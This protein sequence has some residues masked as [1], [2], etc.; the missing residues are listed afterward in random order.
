MKVDKN[1]Y[2]SKLKAHWVCRGFQDKF[3]WD[4]QADSPTATR[5][6]FRLVAQC[7]ANHY[8]D[9]FQLDLKTACLRGEH[10]NLSSRSVVV[11]LPPDI[12]LPPWMVAS[13]PSSGLWTERCTKEMVGRLDKFLRSVGLE[14]TRADRCTY[15]AY[16]GIEGKKDKSYLSTG[17]FS[18]EKEPEPEPP[19]YLKE[20]APH[21]MSCY[22]CDE[23]SRIAS[24]RA[25]ALL[26]LEGTI[27][28]CQQPMPPEA[29]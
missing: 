15:G 14:P 22:A 29:V 10:Y 20:L 4:Q 11:Q 1:G 6:G 9:P 28:F 23:E 5:Y 25:E 19:G 12:G 8:W 27:C 21:A 24:D 7:V 17:S 18:L 16:D 13:L 26:H 3:A 2:F